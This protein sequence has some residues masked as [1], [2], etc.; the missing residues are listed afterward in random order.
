MGDF[1]SECKEMYN[2]TLDN[3]KF[4][5]EKVDT[6]EKYHDKNLIITDSLQSRIDA[7]IKLIIDKVPITFNESIFVCQNSKNPCILSA[8]IT[9]PEN[10]PYDS[11]CIL[12]DIYLSSN[13][14]DVPPKIICKIK[15]DLINPH[16]EADGEVK[17]S[18]LEKQYPISDPSLEYWDSLS[19]T[20]YGVLKNIQNNLF[21][22]H[23][24][25]TSDEVANLIDCDVIKNFESDDVLMTQSINYNKMVR[26]II[27]AEG[28]YNL[29]NDAPDEFYEV[30]MCHFCI[31]NTHIKN[32]LQKWNREATNTC[33]DSYANIPKDIKYK[34]KSLGE[35]IQLTLLKLKN[36]YNESSTDNQPMPKIDEDM[37]GNSEYTW[38][39]D[40]DTDSEDSDYYGETAV[41]NMTAHSANV[42]LSTDIN[43]NKNN[44]NN[45]NSA[46]YAN[47][48]AN[49]CANSNNFSHKFP[50]Y[51]Y[52][53]PDYDDEPNDIDNG[54]EYYDDPSD[55][56]GFSY[57]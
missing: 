24:Y 33:N 27:V 25:S 39:S 18:F 51:A 30:I 6:E 53:D 44:N 8:I 20:I 13:Y 38:N 19:S 5:R 10:T 49:L 42:R 22:K 57:C 54:E 56:M 52:D 55:Y 31:K 47:A 35:W 50:S 11:A 9:G 2:E 43:N 28:I 48:M 1:N 41:Y 4:M 46:S 16:I 26:T 29:L 36:H 7:E 34:S 40:I 12:F 14:P 23:P 37:D 3:F 32:T 21:V 17:A 45:I 15:S